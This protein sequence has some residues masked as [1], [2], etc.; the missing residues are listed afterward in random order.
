MF[1]AAF[2]TI[3]KIWKQPKLSSTD[4]WIKKKW[5]IYAVEYYLTVKQEL[6]LATCDNMGEPRK[7][8]A[9]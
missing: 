6:N 8:Y 5:Y 1:I 4:E 7:Y 9:K 3:A 2:F